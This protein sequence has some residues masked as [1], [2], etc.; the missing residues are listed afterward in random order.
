MRQYTHTTI[1][2]YTHTYAHTNMY[3]YVCMC[4][5]KYMCVRVPGLHAC[6]L[7]AWARLRGTIHYLLDAADV[8]MLGNHLELYTLNRALGESDTGGVEDHKIVCGNF[9]RMLVCWGKLRLHY[10]FRL[11]TRNQNTWRRH[12]T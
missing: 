12:Y 3:V 4:V 7:R 11:V 9:H 6:N 8:R 2:T 5:C 10:Y 1:H